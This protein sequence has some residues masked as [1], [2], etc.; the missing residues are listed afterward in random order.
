MK[1]SWWLGEV[2]VA[3]TY[4]LPGPLD[5]ET[6]FISYIPNYDFN[7]CANVMNYMNELRWLKSRSRVQESPTF[8]QPK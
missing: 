5:E 6:G 8:E 4:V 3:I 1:L 7:Q 2:V